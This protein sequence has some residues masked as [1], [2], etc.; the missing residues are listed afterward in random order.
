M[1]L[2]DKQLLKYDNWVEGL[3]SG[4]FKEDCLESLDIKIIFTFSILGRSVEARVGDSVTHKIDLEDCLDFLE[5]N[6][7]KNE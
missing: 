5:K 4:F 6:I 1:S 3:M 2:S 7:K